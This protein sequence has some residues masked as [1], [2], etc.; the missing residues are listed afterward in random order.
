MVE[1]YIQRI[2]VFYG[3]IFEFYSSFYSSFGFGISFVKFLK[4]CFKNNP[5]HLKQK[6]QTVPYN[7]DSEPTGDQAGSE[8]SASRNPN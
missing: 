1:F 7:T 5:G 2:E 4:R 6:L 3:G 8:S